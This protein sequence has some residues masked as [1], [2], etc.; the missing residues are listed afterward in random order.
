MEHVFQKA[1][2]IT[3]LFVT[4]LMKDLGDAYFTEM[5]KLLA[6]GKLRS[7]ILRIDGLKNAPQATVDMLTGNGGNVGKP[8]VFFS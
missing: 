4:A 1:L 3:G 2:R 5:P 6:E 8:V 7:D